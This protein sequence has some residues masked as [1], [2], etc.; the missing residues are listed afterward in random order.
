MVVR[1]SLQ[2]DE[3]VDQLIRRF[4]IL[5]SNIFLGVQRWAW[6]YV[7]DEGTVAVKVDEEMKGRRYV[8]LLAALRLQ[9]VRLS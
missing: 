8:L 4:L 1:P 2:L 3:G 6:G 7:A 5:L 9:G